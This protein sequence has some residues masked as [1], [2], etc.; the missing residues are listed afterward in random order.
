MALTPI[1]KAQQQARRAKLKAL[2]QAVQAAR[3][4]PT[5]ASLIAMTPAM[6]PSG[7]II[8]VP[9]DD[10]IDHPLQSLLPP[11]D[12]SQRAWDA[13]TPLP[14]YVYDACHAAEDIALTRRGGLTGGGGGQA[15]LNAGSLLKL[16]QGLREGLHHEPACTLAGISHV[17]L[18]D[19]QQ[20]ADDD[21]TQGPWSVIG[22]ALKAAEAEAEA[23]AVRYMRAAGRLPQFWT[24]SATF[25]ERRHMSRWRRSDAPQQLNVALAVSFGMAPELPKI[26]ALVT[27]SGES[28]PADIDITSESDVF[29]SK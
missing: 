1:R 7:A 13:S 24:A 5:A 28:R 17:T 11:Q 20:R 27:S 23:D 10:A 12:A 25:L 14:S 4:V 2:R 18:A 26:Q 3:P 9:R 22:F 19:W 16:L 8:Q 21:T 6:L 15:K 29:P